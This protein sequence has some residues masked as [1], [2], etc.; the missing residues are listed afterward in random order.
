M[1]KTHWKLYQDD[2]TLGAWIF[3]N[4]QDIILTIKQVTYEDFASADGKK[5]KK[6]ILHFKELDKPMVLNAVNSASIENVYETPY[7]EDWVNKKIQL[8]KTS[9][10]AFG[11]DKPCVR[12]RKW[13]PSICAE[14]GNPI[15]AFDKLTAEQLAI[16]T[17]SKYKHPLCSACASKM[18]ELKEG[19]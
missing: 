14:C 15:E 8:Y 17:T 7:I 2:N 10:R 4:E 1:E 19:K 11:E 5:T 13:N 3:K 6:R 12:I 18:K 9:V 16:Y